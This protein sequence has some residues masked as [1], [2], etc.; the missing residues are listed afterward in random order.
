MEK[1]NFVRVQEKYAF[2]IPLR[3]HYGEIVDTNNKEIRIKSDLKYNH[4]SFLWVDKCKYE[5]I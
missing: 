1:G 5:K 3:Y 4:D 2:E